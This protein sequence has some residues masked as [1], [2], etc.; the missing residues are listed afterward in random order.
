[1][2]PGDRMLP[3]L[4]H[5]LPRIGMSPARLRFVT[6]LAL[7]AA[8]ALLVTVVWVADRGPELERPAGDVV[9]VGVVEGQSVVSSGP[10]AV[11]RHPMYAAASLL[12]LATPLALGSFW[13][14]IPAVA[15]CAAIVIR[16]L[17]EERFLI[18]HLAGYDTY[19]RRVRFRL[20]PG[21]W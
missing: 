20:I 4:N 14:V 21:V 7:A 6:G 16:L 3:P 1:M 9:R 13:A 18:V 5:G 19:R 15:L 8:A 10:Y 11:I 12:F 17:D 2:R